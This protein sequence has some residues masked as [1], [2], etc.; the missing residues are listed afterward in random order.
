MLWE[1][2]RNTALKAL[3]ADLQGRLRKILKSLKFK[4]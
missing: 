4:E 3:P 2:V 1:S